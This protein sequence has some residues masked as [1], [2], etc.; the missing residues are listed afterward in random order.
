MKPWL[1]GCAALAAV[2]ATPAV[3]QDVR[4]IAPPL[5]GTLLEVAAEGHSDR[6]PDLA[7]IQSGVVTQAPTAALAMSQNSARMARVL[8]ALRAAGVAE[9]DMRTASV[10]LSPQYR[11]AENKPPVITGYQ[12]SNQ[13]T[14]RFRDIA[15]AGAILDALVREGANSIDGPNL[16]IENPE[17]AMDEARTAAMARARARADLYARAAGLRVERILSISETGG[18]S[19]P[20]PMN[21]RG[22]S[23]EAAQAADTQIVP[24]EQ[25]VSVS[26]N[27]RFLLK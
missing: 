13:V 16:S 12:A 2:A 24:G 26:V 8:A 20:M 10:S 14:V 5:D 15:K 4:V 6:T 7:T 27:V 18:W 22:F 25:R 9:R 19:P 21:L 11:H 3:A 17:S 23:T 1:I